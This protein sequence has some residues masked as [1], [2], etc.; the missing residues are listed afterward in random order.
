[1]R[2]LL[3]LINQ[4]WWTV[5]AAT[6]VLAGGWALLAQDGALPLL[7]L[8]AGC[9][10]GLGGSGVVVSRQLRGARALREGRSGV[11]VIDDVWRELQHERRGLLGEFDQLLLAYEKLEERYNSLTENLAAAIVIRDV[12][13]K[14]RYC[15]PYTEVLTGYPLAAI[16]AEHGDFLAS[17]V[18]EEDRERYLRALR[19]N[20]I[21]EPFHVRYRFQ[22]RSGLEMWAEM[23]SV[24][25]MNRTQEVVALLSI[26]LDVTASV[27]YQRQVEEKNRDL[28]DF[29]YMVSHDL[30]APLFT[31]KGMLGVIEQDA[32]NALPAAAREPLQHIARASDRLDALIASV[33]EYAR[34]STAESSFEPIDVERLLHD[35]ARDFSAQLQQVGGTI[36]VT[37]STHT[38][39][40]D[41]LKLYQ[42][43]ANLVGNAIKYRHPDRPVRIEL[44]ASGTARGELRLE[45]KDNG[46]GIPSD[47]L[48]DIFRPFHRAH[49]AVAQ[50]SGIGLACVRRLAEKLGGRVEVES[51]VEHGTTFT[52]MIRGQV[53]P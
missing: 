15:S 13:G 26:T 40:T 50:G 7:T 6:V 22:H 38:L 31:I 30:K 35:V 9:A 42:I 52:V 44:R 46:L 3:T 27:R 39:M 51:E 36:E 2:L 16:Y 25:V 37:C 11:L 49:Q 5:L 47:R 34:V 23:R 29:T 20:L 10:I 28:E 8:L 17:I 1:M 21:G 45:V 41:K 33:L 4:R 19:V 48:E 12:D 43:V 53:V 32:S 14:I 24:P 18:H